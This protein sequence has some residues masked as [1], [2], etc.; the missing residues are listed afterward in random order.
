[1]GVLRHPPTTFRPH[2]GPAVDETS[3]RSEYHEYF[4]WGKGGRCQPYHIHVPIFMKSVSIQLQGPSGPLQA[5]TGINHTNI[6][7]NTDSCI[8]DF[9]GA[10]QYVCLHVIHWC[11]TE[12][13][14]LYRSF[15]FELDGAE[16]SVKSLKF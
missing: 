5:C 8:N 16:V 7:L 14:S 15:G 11:C 12:K 9:F 13:P 4:L 2:C 3:N 1:M 6:T 10:C